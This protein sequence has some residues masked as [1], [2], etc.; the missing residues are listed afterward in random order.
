MSRLA[1]VSL[2]TALLLC[3]PSPS[4]AVS[5]GAEVAYGLGAATLNIVYLPMKTLM[6][7]GGGVVGAVTGLLTG[8]DVRAAYS[9]WVPTGS[10]TYFLR[11][12]HL[13][14]SER[15][16]FFGSDYADTPS[17][18]REGESRVSYE[19]MYESR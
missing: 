13:E 3:R 17:A 2:L 11:S 12:A 16:E 4:A 14:G 8:G 9:I 15:V 19:A 18:Y 6:A 1:T 10:G 7:I 5:G